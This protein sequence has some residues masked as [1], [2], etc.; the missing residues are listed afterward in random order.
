MEHRKKRKNTKMQAKAWE[1]SRRKRRRI[2]ASLFSR[3]KRRKRRVY[4]QLSTTLN[5]KLSTLNLIVP[6]ITC[7]TRIWQAEACF[8]KHELSL[9]NHELT[10]NGWRGLLFLRGLLL[11]GLQILIVFCV[12]LQICRNRSQLS[13]L[14]LTQTGH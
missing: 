6:R 5:I 7:I 14:R 8:F 4:S 13:N 3:R 9:I 11:Y 2:W 1:N 12:R 10:I